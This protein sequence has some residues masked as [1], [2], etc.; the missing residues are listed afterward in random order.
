MK[1]TSLWMRGDEQRRVLHDLTRITPGAK[2]GDIE[3][4][5]KRDVENAGITDEWQSPNFGDH[6][7][8]AHEIK[9]IDAHAYMH[10]ER[11][12]TMR[13]KSKRGRR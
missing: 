7:A 5:F 10:K 3:A 12:R 11:M 2:V 6:V 1:L 9:N 13:I 8:K 4:L